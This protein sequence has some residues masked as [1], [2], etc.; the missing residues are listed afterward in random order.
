MKYFWSAE[1]NLLKVHK[2]DMSN[3]VRGTFFNNLLH[4]R[5][6]KSQINMFS[7]QSD[8]SLPSPYEDSMA[9]SFLQRKNWLLHHTEYAHPAD[10]LFSPTGSNCNWVWWWPARLLCN[11]RN[12]NSI[13]S[14][15]VGC[16]SWQV[17]AKFI[18]RHLNL[19]R[20]T[21]R[22]QLVGNYI[23]L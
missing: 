3:M 6:M 14:P 4:V 19:M 2:S 5:L 23:S 20:L 18:W 9:L 1:S 7:G 8:W 17:V 16:V 11:S 15:G 12:G 10:K 22:L 21:I 13:S